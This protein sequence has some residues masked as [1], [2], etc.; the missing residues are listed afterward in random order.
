MK[1]S[2]A[3]FAEINK[4][5]AQFPFTLRALNDE[6]QARMGISECRSH[7]LVEEYPV[8]YE[9]QGDQVV[10]IKFTLLILPSGPARVTGF[11]PIEGGYTSDKTEALPEDIKEVLAQVVEKK[12]KKKKNNKK[13]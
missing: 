13:K 11:I 4:K 10:H 12:K 8:I 2:R 3:T 5:F 1:A 7:G 6:Q 9:R